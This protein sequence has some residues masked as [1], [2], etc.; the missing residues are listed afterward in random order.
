MR[1]YRGRIVIHGNHGHIM[2]NLKTLGIQFLY[3]TSGD[4]TVSRKNCR[5]AFTTGKNAANTFLSCFFKSSTG[6]DDP[7]RSYF[8]TDIYQFLAKDLFLSFGKRLAYVSN[9]PMAL[10]DQITNGLGN[11]S[12][13]ILHDMSSVFCPLPNAQGNDSGRQPIRDCMVGRTHE[14]DT[15]C[16]IV[17]G[18][19]M[20]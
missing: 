20:D 13:R 19:I 10:I 16:L 4:I 7:F 17:Y 5:R 15:L 6:G 9:I 3:Y 18:I 2:W 8:Q 14:K 12:T 11:S 1:I